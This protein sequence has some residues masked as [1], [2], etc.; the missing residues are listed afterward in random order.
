MLCLIFVVVLAAFPELHATEFG[1]LIEMVNTTEEIWLYSSTAMRT[2]YECAYNKK[3]SLDCTERFCSYKYGYN[4]TTGTAR[5]EETRDAT[6]L[7]K[8]PMHPKTPCMLRRK[9]R[10]P[11]K[12]LLMFWDRDHHCGLFKAEGLT[13]R[14][15]CEIHAWNSAMLQYKTRITQFLSCEERFYN[16]C[17]KTEYTQK[18]YY[19]ESCRTQK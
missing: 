19:S 2:D 1:D 4:Y 11:I 9:A 7:D 3:D 12:M 10:A 6:L 18:V 15:E 17:N 16:Y 14:T 8:C 13:R 5:K